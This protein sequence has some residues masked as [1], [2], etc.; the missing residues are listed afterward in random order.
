MV[1]NSSGFTFL[2]K[3][4]Y[5][6]AEKNT[7]KTIFSSCKLDYCRSERMK[8]IKKAIC[9]FESTSWITWWKSGSRI[10]SVFVPFNIVFAKI[11]W[12][13]YTNTIFTH[14]QPWLFRQKSSLVGFQ[15]RVNLAEMGWGTWLG[16]SGGRDSTYFK[17]LDATILPSFGYFWNNWINSCVR[18]TRENL[19]AGFR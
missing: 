16:K 17:F 15:S 7:T 8:G 9:I 12:I 4:K 10:F 11:C 14:C 3:L 5:Y 2:G 1:P 18:Q 6:N 13:N 19:K